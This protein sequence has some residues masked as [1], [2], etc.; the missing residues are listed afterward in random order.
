MVLTRR[1][2]TVAK[3]YVLDTDWRQGLPS[4]TWYAR[5]TTTER[6]VVLYE[7]LAAGGDDLAASDRAGAL[8]G[9][10]HSAVPSVF[11]VVS[12]GGRVLAVEEAPAGASLEERLDTQSSMSTVECAAV[13]ADLAAALATAAELGIVHGAISPRTVHL[14]DNGARLDHF[15][16]IPATVDSPPAPEVE[17]GH[18]PSAASDIWA[19]GQVILRMLGPESEVVASFDPSHQAIH[20]AARAM[21]DPDPRARPTPAAASAMLADAAVLARQAH[22][23]PTAAQAMTSLFAVDPPRLNPVALSAPVED[24]EEPG[25]DHSFRVFPSWPP[26]ARV[27][28]PVAVLCLLVIGVLVGLLLT[29]GTLGRGSAEVTSDSVASADP[30][31]PDGW[32]V[33][34]HPEAGF[35]LAHPPEWTVT[36]EGT[37]TEFRDPGSRAFLRADYR[38]DPAASPLQTWLDL[39]G[40][41]VAQFPD[42]VRL[43]ITPAEV[44]GLEAAIWEFRYSPDGEAVFHGVDLGIATDTR[45]YALYFQTPDEEWEGSL[46]TFYD[47]AR[48]F[49]PG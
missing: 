34:E 40:G 30:V 39:E 21:T 32:E 22:P 31:V 11:D 45:A 27:S 3:R 16:A 28:I 48:S 42:Y 9:L 13:A 29:N 10:A 33:F 20:D 4:A 25:D 15:G 1:R 7:V 35:T 5:D 8:L 49:S 38:S 12:H 26:P 2:R 19:L 47:F 17:G 41:F 36:Q 24:E 46:E 6:D 14:S 18:P 44:S 43:Q 23:V 37:V